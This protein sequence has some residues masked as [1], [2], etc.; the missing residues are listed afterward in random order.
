VTGQRQAEL[1]EPELGN[2]DVF[3][4]NGFSQCA[5]AGKLEGL[6]HR[7][8]ESRPVALQGIL[9]VTHL[10][11]ADLG[12]NFGIL[13]NP[14]CVRC[15]WR[16]DFGF[17]SPHLG[18]VRHRESDEVLDGSCCGGFLRNEHSTY[19]EA[20]P[21]R[22][23]GSEPEGSRRAHDECPVR[24]SIRSLTHDARRCDK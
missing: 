4:C 8:A 23:C 1:F 3:V 17:E 18:V 11:R 10:A 16:G 19:G 2:L 9:G 7:N 15:L 21:A 6:R 20:Q 24:W 14:A 5:L 22:K 12:R 13:K